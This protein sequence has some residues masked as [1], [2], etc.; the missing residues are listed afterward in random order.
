MRRLVFVHGINNQDL[1]KAQIEASWSSAFR[2][3]LGR[4]AD[5]WW[6]DVEIRTAYYAD[7]LYAEEQSWDGGAEAVAAM[8]AGGPNTDYA[9]NDL[10]ALYLELQRAHNI[11][12]AQVEAELRPGEQ[13]QASRMAAGIHKSWL[14][15]ITRALEKVIPGASGGL[16]EKFL[17]QAATY[18]NKPGVYDKINALVRGQVFGDLADPGQTVI[19]SHSLGTI[20]SYVLL[21]QMPEAPQLPL[22]VTLGSPLGIRMVRDRIQPPFI[23]P[24]IASKWLNGADKEDFVA[25]QPQLDADTFGPAKLTNLANLD[26]GYEDAHSIEKYLAQP[27][28]ALAIGQALV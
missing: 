20:V 18:L 11:S 1:T 22:F 5:S 6:D 15:A 19:V 2:G 4:L 3:T 23:T 27:A 26:N 24:P 14:K 25:L 28:I 9:P 7:V 10:A 8:A 12:D 16:A 13:K 17:R 21:R